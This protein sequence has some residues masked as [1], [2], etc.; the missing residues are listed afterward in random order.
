[1]ARSG[2]ILLVFGAGPALGPG[3][4]TALEPLGWTCEQIEDVEAMQQRLMDLRP[5]A[6]LLGQRAGDTR[7]IASA[8]RQL[9]VPVNGTPILTAGAEDLQPLGPGRHVELPLDPA[10]FRELLRR[11]AGP[12]DDHSSREEP[13]SFRYRLIRLVGLEAADGMLLRLKDS[14]VGAV[15]AGEGEP[16]A[17]HR[18][19]GIAGLC[20]F[21]ELGGL[22][23]RVSHGGGGSLDEAVGA[24]RAVIAEIDQALGLDGRSAA[25]PG[26]R[27]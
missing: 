17:A 9:P 24:S 6:I 20:G 26:G 22:W 3:V 14:L 11:W 13:W 23:S 12:L 18:L 15:T 2:S 4:G 19:A 21:A 1:M 10:S 25:L 8:I 5:A 27:D 16:V 7:A